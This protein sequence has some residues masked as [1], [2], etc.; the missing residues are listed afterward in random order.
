MT[1]D[2][3]LLANRVN[4]LASTGPVSAA[5]KRRSA[6]NATRHGLMAHAL[7]P[8]ERA[9][10]WLAFRDDVIAALQASG[11]L[12]EAL[13]ERYA[14]LQWRL[15]RL[16]PFEASLV[17]EKLALS[18]HGPLKEAADFYVKLKDDV[19]KKR[20]SLDCQRREKKQ[21]AVVLRGGSE[22]HFSGDEASAILAMVI[23]SLGCREM[24]LRPDQTPRFCQAEDPKLLKR[25]GRKLRADREPFEHN[26]WEPATLKRGFNWIAKFYGLSADD[27][28]D[29]IRE[30]MTLQIENDENQLAAGPKLRRLA[31]KKLALFRRQVAARHAV[32]DEV[33]LE[34]VIRYESHLSKQALRV[35][36]EL[37]Q[38]RASRAV[39]PPLASRVDRCGKPVP[40]MTRA[41]TSQLRLPA[42]TPGRN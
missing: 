30:E 10:D 6:R 23:H 40:G 18:Q 15:R 33:E 9:A 1:A 20:E 32:P 3:Q 19:K 25:M 29:Y 41:L 16:L 37:S 8:G 34:K 24:R 17:A 5:G 26:G 13:A 39:V 42:L 14:A 7:L 4:A 31:K 36:T 2:K 35:L 38:L 27:A 11:I 21:L 22:P 12:E 28:G